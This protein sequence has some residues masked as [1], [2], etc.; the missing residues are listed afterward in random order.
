MYSNFIGVVFVS[1][2]TAKSSKIIAVLIFN[3]HGSCVDI[4]VWRVRAFKLYFK[5]DFN[6]V[7][8]F[9]L[10]LEVYGTNYRAVTSFCND[11]PSNREINEM[12]LKMIFEHYHSPKSFFKFCVI[13]IASS[14]NSFWPT[15]IVKF[16]FS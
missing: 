7:E 8:N 2:T 10:W 1:D 5:V 15:W 3:S 11:I 16:D 14:I 12:F 13:V 9:L 4:I 6:V